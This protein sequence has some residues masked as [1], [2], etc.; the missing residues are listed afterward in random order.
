METALLFVWNTPGVL[1]CTTI[2]LFAEKFNQFFD[3]YQTKTSMR[4]LR[5]VNCERV[6]WA[7]SMSSNALPRNWSERGVPGTKIAYGFLSIR[8]KRTLGLA[9]PI[10][11]L[12]TQ[13]ELDAYIPPEFECHYDP[14]DG[15][16]LD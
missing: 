10:T 11:W 6:L 13:A 7:L 1:Q 9:A 15:D 16:Y 14:F 5:G 2:A 12:V 8:D 3:E 4:T